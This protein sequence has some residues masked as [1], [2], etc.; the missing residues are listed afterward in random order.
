MHSLKGS[1]KLCLNY[2]HTY[3]CFL[4]KYIYLLLRERGGGG[5]RQKERDRESH[6]A[7]HCQ[8]RVQPV[9]PTH[10]P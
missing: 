7:P 1:F 2:T 8:S 4:K 10:E 9:A 5:E 6:Q 3:T